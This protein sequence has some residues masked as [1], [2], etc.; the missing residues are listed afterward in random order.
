MLLGSLGFGDA[1]LSHAQEH[2]VSQDA[3]VVKQIGPEAAG[4]EEA[5]LAARRLSSHPPAAVSE[6]L[7]SMRG[8]SPLA[9]NWLRMIASD[10]AD[11]GEF[12]REVLLQFFADRSQ[13]TDARH[14]A[15]QM[16]VTKDPALKPKLL[17][18][19]VDDPSLPVRHA[20]IAKLLVEA[21]KQ[22]DAGNKDEAVE[23]FRAVI[24]QGRNP[25]QLQAAVKSLGELGDKVELADEL[26]LIRRWWVIGTF[27]NENSA[28]FDTAYAPEPIYASQGRLPADWLKDQAV[29]VAETGTGTGSPAKAHVVASSDSFGVVSI[30]PA[31]KNAKDAIAYCYVEF[32]LDE[33][34]DAVARL[35]C[36]TASKVWVNGKF[37]MANEVYHSG[38]RIDQYVGQCSLVPGLNS[39]LIK[40]CQNAQTES[41]AQDWQFQFRLTDRVET[42]VKPV[43]IV[44]PA[45]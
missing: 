14:A 10:V 11:N 22:K 3:A 28:H 25:D 16:L 9:K 38:T 1:P 43:S 26:G 12:P 19:A 27:D 40:I 15:Y 7:S 34:V 30:N 13:D 21:A 39:V 31:M 36:I 33:A 18:G 42:P 6:V 24:S 5:I 45:P 37:V 41:W 44:Q 32:E 35:G 2:S 17:E 4:Y 8:S 29:A 23:L 20:A